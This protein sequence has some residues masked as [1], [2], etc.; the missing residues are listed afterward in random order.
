MEEEI[1]SLKFIVHGRVQGVCFRAYTTTI[2]RM[3]GINGYVKNL[4]NGNVEI[5]AQAKSSD[6]ENFL[7]KIRIGP[8]SSRVNSID[9]E[10]LSD[11]VNY[12][13]FNISF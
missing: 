11:A 8:P 4:Y 3:Y 12:E 7:K 6:I 10:E 5:V 9:I 1:K 13:A 2:A